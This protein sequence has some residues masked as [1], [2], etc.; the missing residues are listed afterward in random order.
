MHNWDFWD[1]NLGLSI[2]HYICNLTESK[3]SLLDNI[4]EKQALGK[5]IQ[6]WKFLVGKG[7]DKDKHN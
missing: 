3:V 6:I 5:S 7:T 2:L 4:V 1:Q